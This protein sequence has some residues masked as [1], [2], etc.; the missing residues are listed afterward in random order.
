[1]VDRSAAKFTDV[2]FGD[3]INIFSGCGLRGGMSNGARSEH[4]KSCPGTPLPLDL[5]NHSNVC[6]YAKSRAETDPGDTAYDRYGILDWPKTG[7]LGG[8]SA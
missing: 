3:N 4:P 8:F 1:M 7:L 6:P 5:I 2:N